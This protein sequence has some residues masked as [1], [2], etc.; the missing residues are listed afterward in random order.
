MKITKPKFRK[1]KEEPVDENYSSPLAS[2]GEIIEETSG[3]D[4]FASAV[5]TFGGGLKFIIS[6]ILFIVLALVTL[7]TFLSGTL[8]FTAPVQDSAIERAWVARGT[9]Q[10]GQIDPE[11]VIYGSST[12][13]AATNFAGKVMEGYVG[14][15]EYF[16]AKTIA[17]PVANV[18]SKN[19]KIAIN[20][21]KTDFKGNIKSTKLVDQY[22][23]K[24]LEGSCEPGEYIV[25]DYKSVSGEVRGFLSP[26]GFR[27]ADE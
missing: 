6:V 18:S 1:Q 24:C 20:G 17:G 16:V 23:A 12:T 13:P 19:G 14:A 5:L 26:L 10:G 15:D 2:A 25:L 7:Y 9:F 4:T 8:M 21:K 27:G 22:L 11:R 3:R